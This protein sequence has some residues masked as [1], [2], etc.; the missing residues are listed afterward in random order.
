MKRFALACTCMLWTSSVHADETDLLQVVYEVGVNGNPA[1]PVHSVVGAGFAVTTG[2]NGG[3]SLACQVEASGSADSLLT[4]C[5]ATCDAEDS[6]P[7]ETSE[8]SSILEIG[9]TAQLHARCGT[10]TAV[11]EVGYLGDFQAPPG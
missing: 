9:Y 3:P 7:Q 6:D 10:D 1:S 8:F 5:A 4:S 11:F 2:L